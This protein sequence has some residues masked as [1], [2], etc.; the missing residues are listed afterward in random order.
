M[1]VSAIPT[2][3]VVLGSTRTMSTPTQTTTPI[4]MTAKVWVDF[5]TFASCGQG[6][7]TSS[8]NS[9]E[10][11]ARSVASSIL[12]HGTHGSARLGTSRHGSAR[13]GTARHGSALLS[14]HRC[15]TRPAAWAS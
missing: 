6:R 10:G 4:T 11:A 9:H 15:G 7:Y 12:Y 13:L 1:S 2:V 8:G 5:D 14:L 3:F